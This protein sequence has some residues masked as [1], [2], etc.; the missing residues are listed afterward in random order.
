MGLALDLVAGKG[1]K[2]GGGGN[3]LT[4]WGGYSDAAALESELC[5]IK[6]LLININVISFFGTYLVSFEGAGAAATSPALSLAVFL[7][8]GGQ[9]ATRR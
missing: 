4:R 3:T 1:W 2:S 9:S 8:Q 6:Y 7:Q 5:P